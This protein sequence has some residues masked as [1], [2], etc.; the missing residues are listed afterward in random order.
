MR[1]RAAPVILL[2]VVSIFVSAN[3]LSADRT[4]AQIFH[5]LGGAKPSGNTIKGLE[6]FYDGA[7]DEAV[8][9]LTKAV[10]N[11]TEH[12]AFYALAQHALALNDFQK[13]LEL[14]CK[15]FSAAG[16]SSWAE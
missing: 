4:K 1:L 2:F 11:N 6:Q 5:P 10:K 9:T 13:A 7:C 15:A 12:A 14:L 8:S 16:N 3:A